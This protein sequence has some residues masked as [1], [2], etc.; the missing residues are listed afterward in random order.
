MSLQ[1][2]LLSRGYSVSYISGYF[3]SQT[4]VAVRQFQQA[5]GLQMTGAFD[6]ATRTRLNS[7]CTVS[8]PQTP[9]VPIVPTQPTTPTPAGTTNVTPQVS[10]ALPNTTFTVSPTSITLGQSVNISATTVS[11][12]LTLRSEAID[13]SSN[14]AT[15]TSGGPGAAWYWSNSSTISNN[16]SHTIAGTFTPTVAGTYYFRARGTDNNGASSFVYQTLNVSAAPVQ[17]TTPTNIYPTTQACGG[18]EP[19]GTGVAKGYGYYQTGYGTAQWT[20]VTGSP[21]ACQWTCSSG[22]G[23]SGNSCAVIG[24][25][26]PTYPTYQSCGGTEPA[27]NGYVT[28]GNGYYQTGY[29]TT[30]WT[31]VT[32]SP[33]ACQYG[34]ANGGVYTGNSCVAPTPVTAGPTTSF[35]LSSNSI[36]LG[37]SVN[38]IS[39]TNSPSATLKNAAIDQSSNNTSW[40]SGAPCGYWS[41][42]TG[43][44][45]FHTIS[46]SFTPTAAGIYYF[47]SRGT[48]TNGAS[49]FVNQTLMVGGGL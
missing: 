39:T 10:T 15:W 31:F 18:T 24:T 1:R 12:S 8:V 32:S 47:R 41:S 33:N 14:N 27:S 25:V 17:Q 2:F 37:Q 36:F 3:G 49:N 11:P 19:S 42:S 22:Y 20:F 4:V 21:T 43:K 7:L 44:D 6:S 16:N 46:C 5:N 9:V 45:S 23:L 29:S 30:Q 40:A 34:C 28:K 26:A 48:D 35:S 38:L 13:L